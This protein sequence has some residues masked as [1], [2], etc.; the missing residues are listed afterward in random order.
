MTQRAAKTLSKEDE[1]ETGSGTL[2]DL[3]AEYRERL[4]RF[5]TTRVHGDANTA[6]DLVQETFAAALAAWD[7]SPS[8]N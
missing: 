4:L 8:G 7:T 5:V 6:E 3:Y 1:V 2:G